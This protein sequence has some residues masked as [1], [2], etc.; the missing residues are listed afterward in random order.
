[1][2]ENVWCPV[3]GFGF[4]GKP[5]QTVHAHNSDSTMSNV[6][7]AKKCKTKFNI[8]ESP[9]SKGMNNDDRRNHKRR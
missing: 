5:L 9:Y 3:S 4:A 2:S 6:L 7:I 1:M 8:Y